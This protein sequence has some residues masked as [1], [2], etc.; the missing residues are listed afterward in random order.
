MNDLPSTETTPPERRPSSPT[1]SSEILLLLAVLVVGGLVCGVLF[2]T[3][4]KIEQETEIRPPRIVK[5]A[6]VEPT[7]E[8]ITVTAFGTVIPSRQL[9]VQPEVRGRV[10]KQHVELEPGGMIEAGAEI[11]AID[12]SDYNLALV[13]QQ[14]A[15]EEA[16][17]ALD[18]ERGRQVVALREWEILEGDVPGADANRSLVL[19]QPHLRRAEALVKKA[20]NDIAQAELNLARTSV[21]ATFNAV[22]IEESVEIGQL[23]ER[24]TSV[25]TFAGAD[26]FWVRVSVP[27][28]ML[29]WIELPGKERQGAMA[30]IMLDSND[31]RDTAR[32]GRVLRLLGDLEPSGR[33]AR[34]LVSI[35]NPLGRQDQNGKPPLLLGSYVEVEIDAGVLEDVVVIG[36]GAL[37][38]GNRIWVVDENDE[39]KI[40][41]ARVLWSRKDSV[42]LPKESIRPGERLVIS[43]LRIAL[44]GMKVNPQP[45]APA[46]RSDKISRKTVTR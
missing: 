42:L 38:E 44:P 23:L 31:S 30:S 11:V 29:R 20:K 32:E 26:E 21:I 8:R 40:R 9:V 34:M 46:D 1:R 2:W 10:I 33:M 16:Q 13:A 41:D 35:A 27:I 43:G 39:L 14:A 18:V 25:A 7:D 24:G 22:V 45:N 4:P 36:R 19:R 5:T 12:P 28:D 17:F 3:Q 15:L 6:V 37:R